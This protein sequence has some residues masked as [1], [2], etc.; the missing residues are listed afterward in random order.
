MLGLL[1]R[2]PGA[3]VL[4]AYAVLFLAL[5]RYTTLRRDVS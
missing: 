1:E 4:V 2:G 3:I 5:G